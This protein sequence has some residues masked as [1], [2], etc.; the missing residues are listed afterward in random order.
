MSFV[1]MSVRRAHQ[2][3]GD[4]S[5]KR[6]ALHDKPMLFTTDRIGECGPV[7]Q[8]SSADVPHRP[9]HMEHTPE[10]IPMLGATDAT[11]HILDPHLLTRFPAF[12][13][14]QS[15]FKLIPMPSRLCRWQ[16]ACST[17][18]LVG[19]MSSICRHNSSAVKTESH[20][21]VLRQINSYGGR[22]CTELCPQA[23]CCMWK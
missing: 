11:Y 7:W 14:L 6:G 23:M 8:I 15:S 10:G 2:H 20:P 19:T 5:A 18:H 21:E 9:G 12:C 4:R 13:A 17:F 22:S 16:E 1:V 3:F